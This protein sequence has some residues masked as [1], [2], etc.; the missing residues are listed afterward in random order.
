MN[1][2]LF[3][4][5]NIYVEQLK[6]MAYLKIKYIKLFLVTFKKENN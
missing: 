6:T 5:I 3:S 4:K 1:I 2:S